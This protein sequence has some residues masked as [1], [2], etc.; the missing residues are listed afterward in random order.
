MSIRIVTDSTCDLPQS[1][2]DD[3]GIQVMPLYIHIGTA[4]YLDDIDIS[5]EEFYQGLPGYKEHPTTAAPGINAFLEVYKGLAAEG[6]TGVLS[7]HI[8]ETLSNV[9]NVA[10]LAA[11]Q[12]TAVPVTVMDSGQLSL[13]LGMQAR[14][15]A[16]VATAGGSMDEVVA[17]VQELVPRTYTFAALSTVEFLRR[18][19]R[20]TQF[21]SGLATLLRILPLLKMNKGVAEMEKVRTRKKALQRLLTLVSDLG[22]LRTLALVH[23]NAPQEA[24]ALHQQALHLIPPGTEPIYGQVTPV[25]GAHIG[26]GAVGFV[27]I[28]EA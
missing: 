15:A 3:F 11:Q 17:T 22:P 8:S 6:A 28:Q 21:Q 25:I 7:L 12:M 16:Q 18:S 9:V 13:G 2:V 5:R 27:A 1:L 26:P 20:L 24:A 19:G 23:T 10:R 14:A 4:E